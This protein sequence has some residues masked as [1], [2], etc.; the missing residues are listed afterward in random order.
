[1]LDLYSRRRV[2]AGLTVWAVMF[3][4]S[5]GIGAASAPDTV[6]VATGGPNTPEQPTLSSTT[7]TAVAPSTTLAPG[8]S[9][10]PTATESMARFLVVPAVGANESTTARELLSSDQPPAALFVASDL[11][12][13]TAAKYKAIQDE[14]SVLLM[15][16]DEGGTVQAIEGYAGQIPSAAVMAKSPSKIAEIGKIRGQ[17]LAQAGINQVLA[18]VVDR[19]STGSE[20]VIGTRSFSTDAAKVTELAGSYIDGLNA[21]GIASTIKHYP[22]HD[23]A[24]DS[25]LGVVSTANWETLQTK[26]LLPFRELTKKANL[27]VLVGNVDVPGLT[28]EGRPASLS[29]AAMRY[30][31]TD[32]GFNG[33]VITDDLA[34]MKAVTSRFNV[35]TAAGL[36]IAAG[37]DLVLLS[38]RSAATSAVSG[39]VSAVNAG[40][41]QPEV[42]RAAVGRVRRQLGCG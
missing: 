8:C 24:G 21:S 35:G 29:P 41:I 33:V 28:E 40:T 14:F 23:G 16:D 4:V 27:A 15:A 13:A 7:T 39:I 12:S 22:G 26:D 2:T 31:R 42:L 18:P 1:M 37:A 34:A 30:L 11:S 32:L 6:E 10:A 38:D 19:R 36:A 5:V 17:Q 3:L 20:T 9:A 25:H